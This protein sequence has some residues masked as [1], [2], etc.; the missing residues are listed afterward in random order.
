MP[1]DFAT[2]TSGN[3]LAKPDTINFKTKKEGDYGSIK[4]NFKNLEK[5]I[6]PVL[7]FVSNNEVVYS[8]PLTSPTWNVKLFNPGDY[9]LNIL[10]DINQNGRWDPGS[11]EMKKQPEK[12]YSIPQKINIRANWENEKD[13]A[14]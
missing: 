5:F 9:E 1:V 8:Y 6:H 4:I 14:L 2:D 13:I 11:Y 10:D 7:Q 12:V 3:A